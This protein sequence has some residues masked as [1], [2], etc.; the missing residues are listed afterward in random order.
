MSTEQLKAMDQ[1][2]YQEVWSQGNLDVLDEL[3][4][5]N[6]DDHDDPNPTDTLE[7]L[8]YTKHT[9]MEYRSAFPDV[10]FMVEDQIAEGDMVVTRWTAHGTH[11]GVFRGIPPTG[12]HAMTTGI[13]ITRVASGKFV[14][15]WT[16]FDT[17]GLLQQLGVIPPS[18]KTN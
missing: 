12:R 13:S 3:M 9:I 14:E 2:F 10:L 16:I 5:A 4:A 18:V 7:G 15:G 8:E 6:F 11:K 1:R 17:L